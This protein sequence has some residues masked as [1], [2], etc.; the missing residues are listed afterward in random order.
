MLPHPPRRLEARRVWGTITVEE[1]N[2]DKGFPGLSDADLEVGRMTTEVMVPLGD[3][4]D[5]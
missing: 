3:R 1:K 4:L 2:V 5:V